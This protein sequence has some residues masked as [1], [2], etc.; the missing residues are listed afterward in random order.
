MSRLFGS[1]IFASIL[2]SLTVLTAGASVRAEEPRAVSVDR[3]AVRF[4]SSET[5]GSQRPAFLTER[6]L[7]FGARLESLFED[8]DAPYVHQDRFV[9]D[10]LDRH[11]ARTMLSELLVQR[12]VEPPDLLRLVDD[13]RS[14]LVARVGGEERLV[15]AMRAEGFDEI[16]LRETLKRRI[17]AGYYIDRAIHSI[18]SPSE[19]EA[20][21]AFHALTHPFKSTRYEDSR[22]AFL[23]WL[24]HERI[25]TA[26]LEFYQ[27]ARS[28][29][30]IIFPAS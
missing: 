25:R 22:A 26:E 19:D 10:A 12:G 4:I 5:G 13:A 9:R 8:S 21:E 30:R 23:K 6:E 24:A 16:E 29:V 20:K 1:S 27:V 11:I 14:E 2:T 28:R 18:L 7:A 17:R 3:V 15:G